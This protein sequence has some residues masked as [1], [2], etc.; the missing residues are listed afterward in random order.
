[1]FIAGDELLN[2]S[3]INMICY[4]LID[5]TQDSVINEMCQISFFP[6]QSSIHTHTYIHRLVQVH[7]N[8]TIKLLI[9]KIRY[10][11]FHKQIQ[12]NIIFY[13]HYILDCPILLKS[14]QRYKNLAYA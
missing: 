7:A 9:H 14:S 6:F 3:R 11:K 2:H 4:L 8:A 5:Q 13:I 12:V 1:M 10:I